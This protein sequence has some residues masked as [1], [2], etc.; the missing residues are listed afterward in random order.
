MK[1]IMLAAVIIAGCHGAK[2]DDAHDDESPKS[3]N[4]SYLCVGM[5]TSMRFGSCPGCE[6]DAKRIH[7]MM[8]DKFGYKG[9][10]LIS[11]QATKSAVVERLSS[12]V[13]RTPEGGLFLFF[14]SG[15][16]GQE[17][18]G[19]KEPDGADRMDEYLCLY[20]AHM[21]DDEIW[22]IVSKCRGRVFLWPRRWHCPQTP[23]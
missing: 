5:E 14:Y 17:N 23:W 3:N 4:V 20:D 21:L 7:S 2:I 8:K 11:G 13:D 6:I 19:G 16:G 1:N 9:E 12:G 18:L 22:D 10:I 15:H